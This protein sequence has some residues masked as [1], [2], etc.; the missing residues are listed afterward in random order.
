MCRDFERYSFKAN[1]F[2]KEADMLRPF[3]LNV[4]P[5]DNTVEIVS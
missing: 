3:I 4:Y 5:K 1:W 2:Q